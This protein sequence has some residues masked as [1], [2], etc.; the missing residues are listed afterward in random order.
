MIT[1]P[2][3]PALPLVGI[4]VVFEWALEL[5]PDHNEATVLIGRDLPQARLL[6]AAHLHRISI[7]AH[8]LSATY[9]RF[10]RE[11]PYDPGTATADQAAEWIDA[12][13]EPS[14]PGEPRV[15]FHRLS[16]PTLLGDADEPITYT[17]YAFHGTALRDDTPTLV[18]EVAAGCETDREKTQNVVNGVR[19][20]QP[21]LGVPVD[22]QL[23][24]RTWH[25]TG[26]GPAPDPTDPQP[27]DQPHA[28]PDRTDVGG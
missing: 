6:A 26:W 9:A 2:P 28:T 23:Y 16:A 15:S 20:R 3:P 21:E 5:W 12:Y 27:E 8:A 19:D 14:G 13:Q 4:V 22:A 25:T 24:S 10:L 17:E 18:T 7:D 11:H 1:P